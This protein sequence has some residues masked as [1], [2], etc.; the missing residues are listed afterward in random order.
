[1][2]LQPVS[3]GDDGRSRAV[4]H[5]RRIAR[6]V[7]VF[8]V[9]DVRVAVEADLVV[10]AGFAFGAGGAQS[11]ERG[12]EFRQPVQCG[13]GAR[14]L[15]VIQNRVARRVGDRDQRPRKT[16]LADRGSGAALTLD[17]VDVDVVTREPLDRRDEVCG[18][19][20]RHCGI[21]TSEGGV[22]AVD[23]DRT[24]GEVPP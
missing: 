5:A 13:P 11:G 20:L 19:T 18:N 4:D 22:G 12:T 17:C 23:G 1:M 2:G 10:G 14:M 24:G 9:R 21:S 8:E 16:L 7:H 3:G 15:V 6:V